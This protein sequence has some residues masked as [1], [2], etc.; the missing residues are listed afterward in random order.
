MD[1]AKNGLFWVVVSTIVIK[2]IKTPPKSRDYFLNSLVDYNY[3][4][5]NIQNS[6]YRQSFMNNGQTFNNQ[7]IVQ[8]PINRNVYWVPV[9]VENFQNFQEQQ[10]QNYPILAIQDRK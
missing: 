5:S 8:D 4:Q 10:Q 9:K 2:F 1:I 3:S 6:N 7:N